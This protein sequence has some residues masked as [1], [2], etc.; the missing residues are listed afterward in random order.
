MAARSTSSSSRV[1]AACPTNRL[2]TCLTHLSCIPT[3][4]L[5]PRET[6]VN[7]PVTF[8]LDIAF[9]GGAMLRGGGMTGQPP[10]TESPG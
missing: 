7:R 1:W 2:A 6:H 5:K 3:D 8:V 10:G 9:I 4:V